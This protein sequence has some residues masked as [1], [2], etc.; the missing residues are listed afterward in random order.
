[1]DSFRP[2]ESDRAD[3][4]GNQLARGPRSIERLERARQITIVMNV[5]PMP[6]RTRA[7]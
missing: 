3:L 7:Q 6:A 1:M 4:R 5:T 2:V